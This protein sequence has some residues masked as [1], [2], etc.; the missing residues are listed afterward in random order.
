M[1][2]ARNVTSACNKIVR[3]HAPAFQKCRVPSSFEDFAVQSSGGCCSEQHIRVSQ[4]AGNTT[5]KIG[6]SIRSGAQISMH[7]RQIEIILHR[8]PNEFILQSTA[9]SSGAPAMTRRHGKRVDTR[10]G[11]RQAYP[12]AQTQVV[13]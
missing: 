4:Q 11:W 2:K 9:P 5:A 13:S 7:K 1:N 3:A 6:W 12:Q 10:Q 8:E